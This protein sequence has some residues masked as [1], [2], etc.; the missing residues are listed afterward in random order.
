M[1]KKI[2]VTKEYLD[3]YKNR[4][5]M[6]SLH[7]DNPG[8]VE[9]NDLMI[10]AHMAIEFDDLPLIIHAMSVCQDEKRPGIFHRNPAWSWQNQK[11]DDLMV[12]GACLTQAAS[13]IL[14]EMV[15][16]KGYYNSIV[17]NMRFKDYW[18]KGI[19]LWVHPPDYFKNE[20]FLN[21]IKI[22]GNAVF[23]LYLRLIVDFTALLRIKVHKEALIDKWILALSIL[24]NIWSSDGSGDKRVHTRAKC[25]VWRERKWWPFIPDFWESRMRKRF[26]TLGNAFGYYQDPEHPCRLVK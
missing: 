15:A 11:Q 14:E 22:W 9:G 3:R 16:Q 1:G 23:G 17:P 6:G 26:G 8:K 13:L 2:K 4:F 20:T 18:K 7:R 19:D 24:L 5:G 10:S 25:Y 21:K 12:L